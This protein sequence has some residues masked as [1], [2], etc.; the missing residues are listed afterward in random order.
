MQTLKLE[1]NK[2]Y[3]EEIKFNRARINGMH[4]ATK[5]IIEEIESVINRCKALGF[6][7]TKEFEMLRNQLGIRVYKHWPMKD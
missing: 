5:M 6:S 3:E 2:K 1:D 7:T 4:E